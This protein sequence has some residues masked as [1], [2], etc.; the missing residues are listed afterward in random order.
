ML[1][2]EKEKPWQNLVSSFGEFTEDFMSDEI[3][4]LDAQVRESL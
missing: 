1:V 3:S 4:K 2:P